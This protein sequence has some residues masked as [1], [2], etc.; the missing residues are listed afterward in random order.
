MV[1][2]IDD[3]GKPASSTPAA[4]S[5]LLP[6]LGLVGITLARTAGWLTLNDPLTR[7]LLFVPLFTVLLVNLHRNTLAGPKGFTALLSQPFL[8]YLVSFTPN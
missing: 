6:A 1:D 8:V 4:G 7:C 3:E 5:V 2:G